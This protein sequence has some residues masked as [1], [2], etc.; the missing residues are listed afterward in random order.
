MCG[1]WDNEMNRGLNIEI[2]VYRSYKK[3]A[4]YLWHLYNSHVTCPR[5]DRMNFILNVRM[6]TVVHII[7]ITIFIYSLNDYKC[8][9]LNIVM[10]W[11]RTI[12]RLSIL[13]YI[14]ASVMYVSEHTF[15]IIIIIKRHSGEDLLLILPHPR[16]RTT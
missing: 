11:M 9:S 14:L 3:L 16:P 1:T 10:C 13:K 2:K 5:K 15:F 6:Y 8:R 7:T 12:N 4:T